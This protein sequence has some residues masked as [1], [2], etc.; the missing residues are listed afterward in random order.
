MPNTPPS[1]SND[2][3]DPI[4]AEYQFW[5]AN[6]PDRG[7]YKRTGVWPT[8]QD[9]LNLKARDEAMHKA[10]EVHAKRNQNT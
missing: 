6:N 1:L 9:Y 2:S 10:A 7:Y 8:K 4:E 5:L 3:D